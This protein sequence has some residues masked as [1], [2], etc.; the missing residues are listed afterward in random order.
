MKKFLYF[1]NTS[2]DSLMIP[3]DDLIGLE[4]DGASDGI[5]FTFHDELDGPGATTAFSIAT[6]E[7]K[8]REAIKAIAQEIRHGKQ[9]FITVADDV[10]L[11]FLNPNITGCGGLSL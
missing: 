4:I 5:A 8:A 1:R 9:A 7:D 10:D 6:T 11:I 2:T 3:A